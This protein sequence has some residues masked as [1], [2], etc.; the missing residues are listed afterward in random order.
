MGRLTAIRNGHIAEELRKLDVGAGAYKDDGYLTLDISP[1]FSPDFEHDI[2][3][4]P[5]PFPDASMSDV[6]C[7]H[8]LEHLER[9]HLV[10]VMN[11]MHRILAPG[12]VLEIEVP[13]FPYWTAI[14][15][16]THVSFFVPQTFSYFCDMQSYTK[17]MRGAT[18]MVD[19]S[20]HRKLYDI[21]E[22]RLV[23]AFRD[24]MGSLLRVKM[25]KP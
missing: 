15:D 14:A 10:P 16:P 12:G 11:E 3:Q 4:F 18:I 24:E 21:K 9:K 17:I 2:T 5:W 23:K 8:V 20:D 1:V 25:E 6:R 13:I 22:W 19:H 7:L